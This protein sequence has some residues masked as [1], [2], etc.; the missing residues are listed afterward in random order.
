MHTGAKRARRGPHV[1]LEIYSCTRT[2]YARAAAVDPFCAQA[3]SARLCRI[4]DELALP[5]LRSMGA[6]AVMGE[7]TG[8]LMGAGAVHQH[9][10]AASSSDPLLL[11]PNH[12]GTP[13][14]PEAERGFNPHKWCFSYRGAPECGIEQVHDARTASAQCL[15]T[16]LRSLRG[17]GRVAHGGSSCGLVASRSRA[18]RSVWHHLMRDR[19]CATQL[20]QACRGG[21]RR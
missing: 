13:R 8:A 10:I 20:R 12:T 2:R 11:A 4:E 3:P 6:G 14:T 15:L 19:A 1:N 18:G 9:Y 7:V 16:A 5:S 17:A 21:A